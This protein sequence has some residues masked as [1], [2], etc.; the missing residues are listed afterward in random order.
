VMPAARIPNF[1]YDLIC[2]ISFGARNDGAGN[3]LYARAELFIPGSVKKRS[4]GIFAFRS[5][6]LS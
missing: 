1:Q 5:V 6:F 4:H 3:Y 2:I